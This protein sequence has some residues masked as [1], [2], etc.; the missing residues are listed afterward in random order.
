MWFIFDNA[1]PFIGAS[2]D[3]ILSCSR[4]P[5]ACL[6]VKCPYSVIFLSPENPNFSL[7]YIQ[8]VYG[9]LVLKESYANSYKGLQ[10]ISKKLFH[11]KQGTTVTTRCNELQAPKA[12]VTRGYKNFPIFFFSRKQGTTG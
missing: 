3:R 4:Y 8:N 7:P 6:E 12:I 9:K 1:K 2:P 11:K 5:R 10:E